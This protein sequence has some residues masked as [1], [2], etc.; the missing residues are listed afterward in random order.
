MLLY[1]GEVGKYAG[2]VRCACLI[3]LVYICS[4]L[5]VVVTI[6]CKYLLYF[7]GCLDIIYL[8]Y[9]SFIIFVY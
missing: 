8:H 1:F 6:A 2:T 4:C 5:S 3:G 9:Y 7:S